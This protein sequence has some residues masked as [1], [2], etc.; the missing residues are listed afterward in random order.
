LAIAFALFAVTAVQSAAQDISRGEELFKACKNCHEVG[1]EAK[2]KVGP[3]LDGLFGRTAGAIEGFNYSS[4]M[5]KAG[6]D[7]LAWD[8]ESVDKYIEK[9]REFIS[10]NRMSYRGMADSQDRADLIAWLE[11]V[12]VQAPSE[13]LNSGDLDRVSGFTDAVLKIEGDQEYGEY[14]SGDCVTCHQISGAAEGIPS[15]VGI[16]REY[17]IQSLFEYK[18]NIRSNEVMKLRVINL[19]NEEIAA[20]AAY[21]ADLKPQ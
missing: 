11:T 1:S 4:A 8:A 10:G 14:L 16:P 12:S 3:H 20:L 18:N 2:N 19:T 17:F 21:F 5:K 9:P 13:D 6:E 7:G 15:I